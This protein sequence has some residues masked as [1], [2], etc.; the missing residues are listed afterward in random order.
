MADNSPNNSQQS[1][2]LE[3]KR[4]DLVSQILKLRSEENELLKNGKQLEAEKQKQLA[5]HQK[6]LKKI[7]SAIKSQ[8]QATLGVINAYE[9]AGESI[10]SLSDL[11]EGFKHSLKKTTLSGVKMVN[12]IAEAGDANRQT[13]RD[14][15]TYAADSIDSLA[16][17]ANLNE[18]DGVKRIAVLDELNYNQKLLTSAITELEAKKENLTSIEQTILQN[19]KQQSLSIAKNIKVATSFSNMSKEIKEIYEEL[20]EEL[21]GVYKGFKKIS[22]VVKEMFKGVKGFVSGLLIGVGF[23][24][25]DFEKISE[26]IGGTIFD[27]KAFKAQ[28]YGISKILG[29]EA[30]K[31]VINLGKNLGNVTAISNGLAIDIGL[32]AKN[33]HI[34]GEEA[35]DLIFQFGRAQ[36]LTNKIALDS[37]ATAKHLALQNKVAPKAVMEDLAKSSELFALYTRDGGMNI[38]NAGIQAAQL[39]SNLETTEKMA[40]GLL[41]YQTSIDKQFAASVLANREI[42]LD[43]A[44]QYFYN[45]KI[46]EG[47]RAALEAVGGLQAYNDMDINAKR[48]I[49]DLLNVSNSELQKMLANMEQNSLQAAE[50]RDEFNRTTEAAKAASSQIGLMGKIGG[51]LSGIGHAAHYTH[52]VAE[53]VKH[54]KDGIKGAGKEAGFFAKAWGGIKGMFGFAKKPETITAASD[55]ANK[56]M[57]EQKTKN[58]IGRLKGRKKEI[59]TTQPTEMQKAITTETPK[60][61]AATTPQAQQQRSLL[62]RF[63]SA[64][65]IAAMAVVLLALGAAILMVAMA[66]KTFDSV[67]DSGKTIGLFTAAI[68]G[69]TLV[70]GAAAYAFSVLQPAIW[71]MV[72]AFLAFGAS[73]MLVGLGIKYMADGLTK[74]FTSLPALANSLGTFVGLTF[75]ILGLASSI[76][77]LS[78]SLAAL[79]I[80]GY[81]ALPIA[82]ALGAG[83]GAAAGAFGNKNSDDLL[84]EIKGLRNDLST[85]KLQMVM[86]GKVVAYSQN[87]RSLNDG[88][89]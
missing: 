80:T 36:G 54:F 73:I 87:K 6:D 53:N 64:K 18:E 65:Q 72:G 48:S 16:R 31:A 5:S 39:G 3:Q 42:N 41:D 33:A 23:L 29:E 45:G 35:A 32:V 61:E 57:Q 62:D 11:Q 55:G 82:V 2:T 17:L 60:T 27:L 4:R 81:A 37:Y 59:P 40:E 10:S 24:V 49:A 15:A 67:T 22:L 12:A 83:M 1:I 14:A 84:K 51:F 63:G 68:L 52:A 34:T 88:T 7:I 56:L 21:K 86:D 85:G 69:M 47:Q 46:A 13:F 30:G 9:T 66:F 28:A 77:I 26:E 25:E 20:D 74:L 78:A 76:T 70:L 58:M 89:G 19:L 50:Q 8:R 43:L 38:M 75:G 71:P 44:R 79:A